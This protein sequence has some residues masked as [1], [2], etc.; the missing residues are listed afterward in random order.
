MSREGSTPL[1]SAIFGLTP[2]AEGARSQRATVGVRLAELTATVTDAEGRPCTGDRTATAADSK[3]AIRGSI[4][5]ARA[6]DLLDL[7]VSY[8]LTWR[9]SDTSNPFREKTT[10]YAAANPR[11]RTLYGPLSRIASL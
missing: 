6:K 8:G 5:H 9:L 7:D 2:T 4:P 10:R 3:P 11:E 1:P